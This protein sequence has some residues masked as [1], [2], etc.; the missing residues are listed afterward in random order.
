MDYKLKAA[1][2]VVKREMHSYDAMA[3]A[4]RYRVIAPT[5]H[6]KLDTTTLQRKCAHDIWL[7][8]QCNK[9]QRYDLPWS[10]CVP[11]RQAMSSRLKE[12]LKEIE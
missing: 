6:A 11:Y 2:R 7:H 1:I 4:P 12:L 9:C 10:D 3:Q 8:E 5:Q